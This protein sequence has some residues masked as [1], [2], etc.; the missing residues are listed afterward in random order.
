MPVFANLL[1]RMT[2]RSEMSAA[3]PAAP[4]RIAL[5]SQWSRLCAFL[6]ASHDR[7]SETRRYHT[8]AEDQLDAAAYALGELV[9]DL[10]AVMV[11]PQRQS[12]PAIYRLPQPATGPRVVIA[13]RRAAAAA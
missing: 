3:A 5:D 7:V 9:D 4:Q 6:A 13:R 2:A 12:G 10:A 8:A 1:R 11:M